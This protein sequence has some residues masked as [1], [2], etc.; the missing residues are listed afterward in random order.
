M[1]TNPGPVHMHFRSDFNVY[2]YNIEMIHDDVMIL[3]FD[4]DFG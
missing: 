4:F 1:P 3:V 2:T